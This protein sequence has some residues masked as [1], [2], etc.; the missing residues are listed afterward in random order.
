MTERYHD[1]NPTE[2]LKS[3]FGW[4]SDQ[5][6]AAI[7]DENKR[8][9]GNYSLRDAA[10]IVLERAR[11]GLPTYAQLE[12]R[13]AELEAACRYALDVL[14][15]SGAPWEVRMRERLTQALEVTE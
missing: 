9:A 1:V 12:T 8:Q 5:I 6:L 2:E 11:A 3:R 15:D 13:V 4:T 14:K 7:R 10:L